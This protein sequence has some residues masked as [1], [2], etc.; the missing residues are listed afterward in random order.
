MSHGAPK[1]SPNKVSGI[2]EVTLLPSL[3]V[4]AEC[5]FLL[6]LRPRGGPGLDNDRLSSTGVFLYLVCTWQPH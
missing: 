6:L 2:C 4:A 1:M 3:D 5:A